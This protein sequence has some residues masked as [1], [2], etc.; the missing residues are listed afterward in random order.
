[1]RGQTYTSPLNYAEQHT[2]R[3]TPP[4]NRVSRFPS[5]TSRRV[6]CRDL[7]KSVDACYNGDS[8]LWLGYVPGNGGFYDPKSLQGSI[9]CRSIPRLY[10]KAVV[11]LVTTFS[12]RTIFRAK[13]VRRAQAP[14]KTN[15]VHLYHRG[16]R[17]HWGI[18]SK[19]HAT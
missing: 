5:G 13:G 10:S 6:V 2:T 17:R 14:R 4:L 1:M 7:D 18:K 16:M 15:I 11:I 12:L 3:T 8:T 19:R 9:L